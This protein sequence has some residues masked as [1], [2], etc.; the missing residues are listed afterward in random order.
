MRQKHSHG[1]AS[2]FLYAAYIE[3][4]SELGIGFRQ[5]QK[6]GRERGDPCSLLLRKL[7]ICVS[8]PFMKEIRDDNTT[9][10]HLLETQ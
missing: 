5:Q 2:T 3:L 1:G 6:S 7:Q 10:Q 4:Q 8:F 9:V